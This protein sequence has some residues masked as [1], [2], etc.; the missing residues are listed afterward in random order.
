ML[1]EQIIYF[2]YTKHLKSQEICENLNVSSAYITKI[3]KQDSRYLEEKQYRKNISKAKRKLDQNKFIKN[4]RDKKRLEDNYLILKVQQEQAA[5]ELSK[6]KYLN[7]ENFRKWN[8]S[9]YTYNPSKHRYEFDET[10]G[11]AADVPK[12]VKERKGNDILWK[13]NY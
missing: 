3:I 10:L 6:S 8:N 11:R 5:R 7:N 12:Y 1:K 13:K 4:K 9:A 2:Y